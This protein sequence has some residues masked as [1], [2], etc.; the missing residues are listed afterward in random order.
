MRRRPTRIVFGCRL[1]DPRCFAFGSCAGQLSAGRAADHR[2]GCSPAVSSEALVRL[3]NFLSNDG[4]AAGFFFAGVADDH[5]TP[6]LG[7]S[8]V[9]FAAGAPVVHLSHG[10][11]EMA[12][13]SVGLRVVGPLLGAVIGSTQ[14]G[15]TSSDMSGGNTSVRSTTMGVAIGGLVASAIDGLLLAYD[16]RPAPSSIPVRNQLLKIE[17]SPHLALV[18]HGLAVGLSGSL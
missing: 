16:A 14:D 10:Q 9:T 8:G 2:F 6:L 15:K 13:G 11:W 18:P 17:L 7:I 12:L 3:A 1:H 5:N 4:I